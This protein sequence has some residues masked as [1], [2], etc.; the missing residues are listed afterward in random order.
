MVANLSHI[1]LSFFALAC[2]GCSISYQ[3]APSPQ[4]K[5]LA[6]PSHAAVITPELTGTSVLILTVSDIRKQRGN[7]SIGLYGSEKGYTTGKRV[8]GAQVPVS[9]ESVMGQ[10]SDIPAGTYAIRLYHDIDDSGDMNTN[11]FGIPSEPYAF[12]NNARGTMGPAS[13]EKAKFRVHGE[14]TAHRIELN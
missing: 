2:A 14:Q 6:I 13:W 1:S 9:T 10:F 5:I 3:A 4:A 11:A 8:A 7:L 12:S